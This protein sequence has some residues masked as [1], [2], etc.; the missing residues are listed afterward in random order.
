MKGYRI[1]MENQFECINLGI[2]Q[3]SDNR[4][5]IYNANLPFLTR[6]IVPAIPT[7]IIL[8]GEEYI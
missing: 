7:H 8:I 1:K 2:M 4:K 5:G 3:C 6:I